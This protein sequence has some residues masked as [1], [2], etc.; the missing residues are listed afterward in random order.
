MGTRREGEQ[1]QNGGELKVR[2]KRVRR[3]KHARSA[4]GY[5]AVAFKMRLAKAKGQLES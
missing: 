3:R 4:S 2:L 1:S 5:D